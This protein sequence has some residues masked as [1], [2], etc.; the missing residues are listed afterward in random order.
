MW[1]GA[2]SNDIFPSSL[3]SGWIFS[4]YFSLCFPS[5]SCSA[6]GSRALSSWIFWKASDTSLPFGCVLRV[7]K[8]KVYNYCWS[9]HAKHQLHRQQHYFFS[10]YIMAVVKCCT[11]Q[12]H[13]PLPPCV[14]RPFFSANSRRFSHG[15]SPRASSYVRVNTFFWG[16][17]SLVEKYIGNPWFIGN[18]ATL[19]LMKKP[20]QS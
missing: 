3:W 10:V 8:R 18:I 2:A 19:S 7:R 5:S 9:Q 14:P 11:V 12:H 17:L 4:V 16:N 15:A 1:S 13:Q 20:R 6:L